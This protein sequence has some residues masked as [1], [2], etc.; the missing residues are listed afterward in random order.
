[1]ASGSSST[2]RPDTCE[3]AGAARP[4]R[5]PPAHDSHAVRRLVLVVLSAVLVLTA[6]TTA[7]AADA[8]T[9][10]A[11]SEL[12]VRFTLEN[13]VLTVRVLPRAPRSVRRQ[14][15]GHRIQAV[16]G[17]SFSPLEGVEVKRTRVWPQGRRRLRFGFR[18]NISR[19]AKWCLVE[20]R[21]NDVAAVSF[22]G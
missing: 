3:G 20:R 13:R 15:Y 22:S 14:L 4:L 19:R 10:R 1:M 8:A 21:G 5:T 6:L 12:G 18:R 16:C 9:R 7:P 2:R 17:T 11:T